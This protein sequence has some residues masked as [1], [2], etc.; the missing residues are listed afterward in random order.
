MTTMDHVR[1]LAETIGPRG[2]TT[3]KEREAADY[4]AE[5]LRHAGLDPSIQTFTSAKSGWYPSALFA[6]LMLLSFLVFWFAGGWGAVGALL[7]AMAALLSVLRELAFRSNP[8]RWV[9]PRGRSQNVVARIAAAGEA[10]WRVILM[11][12][13]DSHR[14]PLAFSSDGW[15]RLFGLLVPIGLAASVALILIFLGAAVS[16]ATIWR[17]I[18]IPFALAMLGL[19]LI[20]IQ[21]DLTKYTPGANDNASGAAVVLAI[22]ERLARQPLRQTDVWAV[23]SGCEE[24]GCYGAEA[25]AQSQTDRGSET[26]WFTLDSLGTRRGTPCYLSQERFLL[27]ARSDPQLV[28]I[29]DSIAQRRPELGARAHA[30]F[31]G[32]YTES[33]IGAKHGFRVLTLISL[34]PEGRPTE[35]HRPTDV[36][37]RLDPSSVEACEAFTLEF[38]Q[39]VDRDGF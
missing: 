10:K 1:H 16:M 2:S 20:T 26:A 5:T 31:A 12:H 22:A 7:I 21:A 9:L 13:L 4:A 39:A 28:K 8:L 36:V 29:A 34:T 15:L 30:G 27:T 23:L 14:T 11:G 24:V 33:A 6:A 38:L 37:D 17:P 3:S 35:W 25:F 18:S 19:F 32:A